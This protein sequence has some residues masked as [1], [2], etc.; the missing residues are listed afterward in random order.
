MNSI[1]IAVSDSEHH[2]PGFAVEAVADTAFMHDPTVRRWIAEN[3]PAEPGFVVVADPEWANPGDGT[4]SLTFPAHD[5]DA[6]VVAAKW[7]QIKTSAR[8]AD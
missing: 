4:E 7:A 8:A 3:R 6:E 2:V 1:T 5:R